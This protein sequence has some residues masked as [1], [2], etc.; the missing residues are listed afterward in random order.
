MCSSNITCSALSTDD[1]STAVALTTEAEEALDAAGIS[2]SRRRLAYNEEECDPSGPATRAG[3]ASPASGKITPPTSDLV[4]MTFTAKI[5]PALEEIT[6]RQGSSWDYLTGPKVDEPFDV[7]MDVTQAAGILSTLMS[8]PAWKYNQLSATG[9][10]SVQPLIDAEAAGRAATGVSWD[11]TQYHSYD[12]I[13]Q[14]FTELAATSEVTSTFSIG[15]TQQGRDLLVVRITSGEHTAEFVKGQGIVP[16]KTNGKPA[17]WVM[18]LLRARD[19]LTGASLSHL[20]DQLIDGY[21]TDSALTELLD[22]FDFYFL[23]VANPDGYTHSYSGGDRFW[24]K[25]RSPN[26]NGCAGT[27][28]SRNFPHGGWSS[29]GIADSQMC[30]NTYRGASAGSEAETAAIASFIEG[31]GTG[32]DGTSLFKL[33]VDY[34]S[35]EQA[36]LYSAGLKGGASPLNED[37][38]TL[39]KIAAA[40]MGDVNK[41]VF[42]SGHSTA[43]DGGPSLWARDS[44]HQAFTVEGRDKGSYGLVAPQS[45]IEPAAAELLAGLK[46]VLQKVPVSAEFASVR[47]IGPAYCEFD[48]DGVIISLNAEFERS[49]AKAVTTLTNKIEALHVGKSDSYEILHKLPSVK[50]V[51]ARIDSAAIKALHE[52]PAIESVLPNCI[53]E[54]SPVELATRSISTDFSWVNSALQ[55]ARWVGASTATD[56]RRVC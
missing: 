16:S 30:S 50:A 35:F 25:N 36:W 49:G 13:A 27:D 1:Y 48:A 33:F 15:S 28:L 11:S 9:P 37:L 22:E 10:K 2:R 46:A 47:S 45:E 5:A 38:E 54:L 14:H 26:S 7:L 17:V 31:F 39:S 40:A 21:G 51:A 19:H 4:V 53:F 43:A 29:T 6:S 32:S 12:Q 42:T 55:V 18:S 44:I 23:P 41:K 34:R 20:M 56:S 3:K 52:D 8:T 24:S